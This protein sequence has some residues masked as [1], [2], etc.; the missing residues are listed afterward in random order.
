M[1]FFVA[2]QHDATSRLAIRFEYTFVSCTTLFAATSIPMPSLDEHS[3]TE[4]LDRFWSF[5]DSVIRRIRHCYITGL[6]QRTCITLS[7]H[8]KNAAD[9]WSNL[10]L[11]ITGV[12]EVVFRQGNSCVQVLSGGLIIKWLNGRLWCDFSSFN[13]E[14]ATEQ[15]FR[16]SDFYVVGQAIVWNVEPYSENVECS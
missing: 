7:A 2:A 13:G 9:G 12:S 3:I 4:F 11:M 1:V 8:D 14:N 16:S 15:D 5:N 10:S 6:D